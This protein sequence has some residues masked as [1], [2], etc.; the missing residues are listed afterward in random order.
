MKNKLMRAGISFHNNFCPN[1]AM[2]KPAQITDPSTQR[3]NIRGPYRYTFLHWW[4]LRSNRGHR[5]DSAY[6]LSGSRSAR[7]HCCSHT[8]CGRYTDKLEGNRHTALVWFIRCN[9]RERKSLALHFLCFKCCCFSQGLFVCNII[10]ET[11]NLI[12][13]FFVSSRK[14]TRDTL[15]QSTK[16]KTFKS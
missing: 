1:L 13:F 7:T 6:L 12:R 8:C 2:I 15:I 14:T 11:V 10:T 9:I 3:P 16:K 5:S 4:G